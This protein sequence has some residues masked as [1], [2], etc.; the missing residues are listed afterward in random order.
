MRTDHSHG[1]MICHH[2]SKLN[3]V[4]Q[5]QT[6]TLTARA[7][8]S[9][10]H[11]YH[12]ESW[13]QAP[14]TTTTTA[15]TSTTTTSNDDE[16]DLSRTQDERR[17]HSRARDTSVSSSW[18]VFFINFFCYTNIFFTFKLSTCVAPNNGERGSRSPESTSPRHHHWHY[19]TYMAPSAAND[20][21]ANRRGV[22]RV[23]VDGDVAQ[24][25]RHQ[26]KVSFFLLFYF[27]LLTFFIVYA[28]H[29]YQHIDSTCH[30]EKSRRRWRPKRAQTTPNASFE[31]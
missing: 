2:T 20:A 4:S 29:Q 18:Y 25:P 15:S 24:L 22:V 17:K 28:T 6:F 14:T 23:R 8:H 26:W 7:S 19:T 3:I 1:H 21:N 5:S 27:T 30:K 10:K 31:P 13:L 16:R 12:R 9:P 11:R